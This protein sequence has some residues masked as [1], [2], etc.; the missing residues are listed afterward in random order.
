MLKPI[1]VSLSLYPTYFLTYAK[2]PS[3]DFFF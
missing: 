1:K 2:V 3:R